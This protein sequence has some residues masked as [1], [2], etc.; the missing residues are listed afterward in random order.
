MTEEHVHGDSTIRAT[1]NAAASAAVSLDASPSQT[2][3]P[4]QEGRCPNCSPTR[5]LTQPNHNPP[6]VYVIG[7]VDARYPSL[8]V[9][10]E[11]IGAMGR[12]EKAA[13]LSNDAALQMMLENPNNAFLV[14]EMCYVLLVQEVE[15]YILLPRVPQDYSMLVEAGKHELS[16]VIGMRGPIAGPEV[17]NGLTLPFLIFDVIYNFD[18]AALITD[19]SSLPTLP[20]GAD[21]SKF[22]KNAADIFNQV[23]LLVDDGTEMKR[24]L[25][26]LLIRNAEL[27]RNITKAFDENAQVTSIEVKPAPVSSTQKLVDV[28]VRMVNRSNAAPSSIFARVNLDNK[29]PYM[30]TG[31]QP[32][33]Q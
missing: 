27:Y 29:L 21:A 9:E 7:D 26:Y 13:G 23:L 33:W 22:Q 6:W 24:A 5:A 3:V 2:I 20:K 28:V 8:A 10:K 31:W 16:A 15:T 4:A 32:Y 14:R 25:A 12:L 11:A 17:C 30:V 1:E 19:L 18:R